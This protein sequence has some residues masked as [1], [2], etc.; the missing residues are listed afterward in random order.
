MEYRETAE[1]R[2]LMAEKPAALLATV[3]ERA[4][5]VLFLVWLESDF[6]YG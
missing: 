4:Q 5:T 6:F 1:F 2:E 3:L